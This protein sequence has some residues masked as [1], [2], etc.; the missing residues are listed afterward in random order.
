MTEFQM[1][2]GLANGK[3]FSKTSIIKNPA[4]TYSFVGHIPAEL[5]E[6]RIHKNGMPYTGSKIF[7]TME[8]AQNALNA[9]TK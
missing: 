8:E 1:F 5:C 6:D 2:M 9:V 7:K 3:G 4:G